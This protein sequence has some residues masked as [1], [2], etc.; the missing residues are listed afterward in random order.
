MSILE[1]A[2]SKTVVFTTDV[3]AIPDYINTDV[4]GYLNG[5]SLDVNV[6]VNKIVVLLP[7][8]E[9]NRINKTSCF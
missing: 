7:K 8:R 3:G 6:W 2:V 1:S 9:G 5:D 4:N